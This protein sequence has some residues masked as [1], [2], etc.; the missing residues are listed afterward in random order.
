MSEQQIPENK[1]YPN[2]NNYFFVFFCCTFYTLATHPDVS[3]TNL[4]AGFHSLGLLEFISRVLGISIFPAIISL[5]IFIFRYLFFS[6][7][8]S[9]LNHNSF[10]NVFAWLSAILCVVG[11]FGN[12]Q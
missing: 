7:K 9:T 2:R 6:K 10:T 5:V 8:R 12:S 3:P 1:F 11:F 4:L